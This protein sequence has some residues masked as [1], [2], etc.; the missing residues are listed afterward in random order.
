MRYRKRSKGKTGTNW[1]RLERMSDAE[2]RRG[3]A[4]DPDVRHTDEEFW[5]DAKMALPRRRR[6]MRKP[7]SAVGFG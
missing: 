5:K 3:I 6:A 2:I 7:N 4:A 1:D